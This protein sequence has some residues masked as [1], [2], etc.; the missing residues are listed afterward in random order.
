MANDELPDCKP[1]ERQEDEPA[2]AYERFLIYRNMGP[3]R[4]VQAA[5]QS[6]VPGRK[7]TKKPQRSG[8]WGSECAKWSWV[9]RAHEWDI[10]GLSRHGER[11]IVAVAALLE[12]MAV[13]A[14]EG[15]A[16]H[17]PK[18]FAEVI[19]LVKLLGG[20]VNDEALERLRRRKDVR[21]K[22]VEPKRIGRTDANGKVP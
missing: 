14:L 9:E 16:K 4:S 20:Y 5:Y 13:N 12:M 11:A 15:F 10:D 17:K 18:S 8:T 6:T 19:E 1:W 2:E 7:G 22:V 3:Q 21:V